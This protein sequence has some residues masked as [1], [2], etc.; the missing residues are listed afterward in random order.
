MRFLKRIVGDYVG[1][2]LTSC[3]EHPGDGR[4]D[5]LHMTP[6]TKAITTRRR[7]RARRRRKR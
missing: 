2:R 6:D 4:C 1:Y 7:N 5:H 3:S